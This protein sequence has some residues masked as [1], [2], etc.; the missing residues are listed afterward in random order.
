MKVRSVNACGHHIIPCLYEL[1]YSFNCN[2]LSDKM[3]GYINIAEKSSTEMLVHKSNETG[4]CT[5]ALF[6]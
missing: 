3:I 5:T 2:N 1:N 6:V 4:C